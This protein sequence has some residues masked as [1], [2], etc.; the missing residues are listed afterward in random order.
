M[1]TYNVVVM[2]RTELLRIGCCGALH[3]KIWLGHM[4]SVCIYSFGVRGGV[5][6]YLP[7]ILLEIMF[8]GGSHTIQAFWVTHTV[9]GAEHYT[10]LRHICIGGSG[11]IHAE[12]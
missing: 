5:R 4:G 8:E 12:W 7:A 6:D 3:S 11:G 9:T 10:H 2:A 1:Y